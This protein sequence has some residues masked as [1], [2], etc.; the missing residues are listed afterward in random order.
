MSKIDCGSLASI[1]KDGVEFE[2]RI[3]LGARLNG[4]LILRKHARAG[5]SDDHPDYTI[6]YKPLS[7]QERP[8]GAGW[9]KSGRNGDFISLAL[10]DPD[11]L[12]PINLT[13]FSPGSSG[14]DQHWTLV[15]SRP[16]Q[17]IPDSGSAD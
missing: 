13:A 10:D 7:G 3:Q 1:K 6:A 17:S 5:S 4:T 15:W 14:P 8:V 9:I 12:A 16:R 11:W 2:G